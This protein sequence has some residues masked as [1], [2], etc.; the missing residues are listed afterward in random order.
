MKKNF[1]T[2]KNTQKKFANKK[3]LLIFLLTFLNNLYNIKSKQLDCEKGFP[4][5]SIGDFNLTKQNFKQKIADNKNLLIQITSETCKP[6]CRYE[7]QI[8]YIKKQFLDNKDSL[9]GEYDIKLGRINLAKASWFEEIDKENHK[10]PHLPYWI[11]YRN[12]K[13]YSFV[14]PKN[15]KLI[16]LNILKILEPYHLIQ[17][18]KNFELFL[19]NTDTD[20]SGRLLMRTKILAMFENLEEY[21]EILKAF[22]QTADHLIWRLDLTFA[23]ITNR[24]VLK[25]IYKNFGKKFF[26][27]KFDKNSIVIFSHKNKFEDE[28]RIIK[29]SDFNPGKGFKDVQTWI[30]TS[31]TLVMD[32]FTSLNQKAYRKDIP[33]LIAFVDPDDYTASYN[34]ISGLRSLGSSPR[35]LGRINFV[36]INYLDNKKLMKDLGLYNKKY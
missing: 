31:S 34:L 17:S 19:N 25:E 28:D 30:M 24:Q 26:E 7:R 12:G 13:P 32:E 16:V 21:D 23:V 6:C 33:L 9:L 4:F 5:L 3:I 18:Y 20:D 27:E 29:L 22:L 10:V 11:F 35:Y 15:E 2:K 8:H 1:Q 14:A 36:W